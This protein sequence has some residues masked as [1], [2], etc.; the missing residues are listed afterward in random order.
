M[1]HNQFCA[2]INIASAT[3]LLWP[4]F[5][6][7]AT[8][9]SICLRALWRNG[10]GFGDFTQLKATLISEAMILIRRTGWRMLYYAVLGGGILLAMASY[11]CVH[12]S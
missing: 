3:E 6:Y 7:C 1:Q 5:L 8:V 9:T 11:V 2:V 12:F 10:D 4:Y